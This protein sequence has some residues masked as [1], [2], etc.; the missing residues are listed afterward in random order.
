[1]ISRSRFFSSLFAACAMA[2]ALSASAQ[3]PDAGIQA[4]KGPPPPPPLTASDLKLTPAAENLILRRY[5]ITA[6]LQRTARSVA[7]AILQ[8]WAA[9]SASKTFVE[10]PAKKALNA[11]NCLAAR[12]RRVGISAD[13]EELKSAMSTEPRLMQARKKAEHLAEGKSPEVSQDESAC[14]AAGL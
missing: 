14:R 13:I 4:P 8:D 11:Q 9:A 10:E 5:S 12:A 3:V 7:D 1:M 2:L 6:D